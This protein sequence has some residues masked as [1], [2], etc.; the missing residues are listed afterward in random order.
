MA[1]MHTVIY[2]SSVRVTNLLPLRAVEV[3]Y[4]P[5]LSNVVTEKAP[6][7]LRVGAILFPLEST[8]DLEVKL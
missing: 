5:T 4:S 2:S 8:Q 3:K 7:Y 1:S 6:W